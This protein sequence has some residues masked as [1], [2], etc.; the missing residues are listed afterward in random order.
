MSQ[1]VK[2]FINKQCGGDIV[3]WVRKIPYES[4]TKDLLEFAE[5]EGEDSLECIVNMYIYTFDCFLEKASL[6]KNVS[7]LMKT[8]ECMNIIEWFHNNLLEPFAKNML[9]DIYDTGN[10]VNLWLSKF[11]K[12]D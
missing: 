1:E 10:D 5:E 8:D 6:S 9:D 4:T 3:S 12:D 11:I 7:E 2:E